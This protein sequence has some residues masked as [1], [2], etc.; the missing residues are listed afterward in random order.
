MSPDKSYLTIQGLRLEFSEHEINR[1]FFEQGDANLAGLSVRVT[2][3]LFTIS[4]ASLSGSADFRMD[5]NFV[6]DREG[7]VHFQPEKMSLAG[8]PVSRETLGFIS[9]ERGLTINFGG[10]LNGYGLSEIRAEEGR[11]VVLLT[12]N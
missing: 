5:G 11:L 4:G 9:M 7:K 8:L 6:P 10:S 1:T 12:A 3:N 2:P